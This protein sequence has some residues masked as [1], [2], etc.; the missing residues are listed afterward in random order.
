MSES[1]LRV[2]IA[3]DEPLAAER[4]QLLLAKCEGIDLV[5]TATDGD[6][7]VRMAEALTP[8]LLLLDIA[9]PGLDG[10]GVARA[11]ALTRPSP[12]VIFIT[13]FDQFAV[14]AF[15]V[16]AV[17][18]LMKPVEPSRLQRALQ[19]GRDYLERRETKPTARPEPSSHLQE[20]WASDL[21]G[22]VRI[23]ARDIDRVSAER[24]YMRLHV[25][26]RSW[27]IHHSMAALE[28]GLD[29][30]LFVR[31]H[32]SA[33]VRKDFI[34]GFTRNPSGRWIARLADGTEQPVGRLYSDRVRSI[35][36]R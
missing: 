6:S 32:R 19:R 10:I 24:D 27:L 8:D 18:Y 7:T 36:G 11:L 16:E 22:L 12:A 29:P 33:V 2:L 31:L 30:E 14:A 9:M 26:R 13:A 20:F 15:E 1:E 23:A 25:G 4:L 35:A 21:T 3:D 28:E 5:G 34:T 17:D